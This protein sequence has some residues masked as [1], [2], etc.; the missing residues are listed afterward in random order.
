LYLYD[1]NLRGTICTSVPYSRF[2][3]DLSPVI[4]AHACVDSLHYFTPAVEIFRGSDMR[5]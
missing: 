3:G 2:W 5:S 4:Y 1:K